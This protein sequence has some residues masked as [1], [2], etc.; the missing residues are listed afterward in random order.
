MAIAWMSALVLVGSVSMNPIGV[1]TRES[2]EKAIFT[3]PVKPFEIERARRAHQPPN[4]TIDTV[5]MEL[6]PVPKTRGPN[7]TVDGIQ[8]V[9]NVTTE[10]GYWIESRIS[11]TGRE[12]LTNIGLDF[13]LG[14]PDSGGTCMCDGI[15]IPEISPGDSRIDSVSWY[16]MTGSGRIFCCIDSDNAIPEDDETDNMCSL[17]FSLRDDIPWVWQSVNGYCNYASLSMI[18][19]WAGADHTVYETVE[20]ASCPHS[21]VYI[22]DAYYLP[23]GIMISQST[24]DY[25]FAGDLRNMSCDLR[26]VSTWEHYRSLICNSIDSG[27]PVMTSVDPYYL[28]EE[29]Y[30]DLWEFGLHGGHAVV[31]TGYTDSSVII[32]DPGVGL[33]FITDPIPHPELRGADVVV[34]WSSF[35]NAVEM[36]QGTSRIMVSYEPLGSIPTDDEMLVPVLEQN[37]LRLEGDSAS[38]DDAW[39]DYWPSGWIPTFGIAALQTASSDMNMTTFQ[40]AFEELMEEEDN[41]LEAVILTMASYLS[42]GLFWTRIGWEASEAYYATMDDEDAA[43]MVL[44]SRALAQKA[45]SANA[46][47]ID[48]IMALWNSGGN[49]TITGPYLEQLHMDFYTMAQ[50][51][52]TA[53]LY[54]QEILAVGSDEPALPEVVE[55]STLVC[56]PNPFRSSVTIRVTG[57]CTNVDEIVIY[58]ITGRRIHALNKPRLNRGDQVFSWDGHS[59]DGS[60]AP[61]G[62]YLLSDQRGTTA[63]VMRID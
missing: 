44:I 8:L 46:T 47:V 49:V 18:F 24:S 14:H 38:Y 11:N 20:F 19:N 12:T 54:L 32:N 51:E 4:R 6:P 63:R 30:A 37:I 36:T 17:S 28:P 61:V 15:T 45:E 43:S 29:D 34:D 27:T 59:V 50:M 26:V 57:Q 22:D 5:T 23:G 2:D 48:L 42:D 31:V 62:V 41:D 56:S 35:R 55:E 40:A 39:V 25:E 1:T 9:S 52:A 10:R 13:F 3:V 33:G 60:S 16:G 21:V 7:L 53:V 58:D